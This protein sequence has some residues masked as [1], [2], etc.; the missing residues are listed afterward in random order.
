MHGS[1][2]TNIPKM[3][4]VVLHTFLLLFRIGNRKFDRVKLLKQLLFYVNKNSETVLIV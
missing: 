1:M 3:I 2:T 4:Q